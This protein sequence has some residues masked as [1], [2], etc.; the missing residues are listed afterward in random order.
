MIIFCVECEDKT[1]TKNIVTGET[2]NNKRYIKGISEIC[3]S[4]K[5]LLLGKHGGDFVNFL[6]TLIPGEKHLPKHSFTGPG[7]N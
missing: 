2:K 5:I 7:T 6:N 1:E 3:G 4:K